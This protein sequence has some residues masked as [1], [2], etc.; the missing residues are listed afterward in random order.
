[1]RLLFSKQDVIK[2]TLLTF[3]LNFDAMPIG[4]IDRKQV[5]D[6]LDLLHKIKWMLCE[7]D[8]NKLVAASNQFYSYFPHGFGLQRPPIIDTQKMVQEK[9]DM[10]KYKLEKEHRYELLTSELNVE[11]NLLDVCY[12]HLCESADINMLNKSSGMY[13]QICEYVQNTQLRSDRSAVG[14][15]NAV[16][17]LNP[18]EVNEVYEVIRHEELL[19]YAPYEE[20]FNRQLLFHG[21]SINNFCSILT[22]GLKIAPP[23]ARSVFFYFFFSNFLF[24]IFHTSQFV[25]SKS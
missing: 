4:L 6:A 3:Y 2:A 1:M 11:R 19:R 14:R 17:Q 12:E 22:N 18:F 9:I 8:Q 15:A 20:N 5:Q 24:T 16:V 23:E 25:N 13:K 10:L 21:T 7:T